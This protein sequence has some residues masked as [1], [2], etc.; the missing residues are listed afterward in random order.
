MQQVTEKPAGTHWLR[1]TLHPETNI[2]FVHCTYPDI[3]L[4]TVAD[5][6]M[7]LF[8][9]HWIQKLW[10]C[11]NPPQKKKTNPKTSGCCCRSDRLSDS[12]CCLFEEELA[13]KRKTEVQLLRKGSLK[14]GEVPPWKRIT[15]FISP[16]FLIWHTLCHSFLSLHLSSS[17]LFSLIFTHS[18]SFSF[19]VEN[20]M[21]SWAQSE[22]FFHCEQ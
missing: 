22:T 4:R 6:W 19:S 16:P 21:A 8:Q 20:L 7:D 11:E 18:D 5:T 3:L 1:Q 2:K 17:S 14:V 15:L 13:L 9:V 10:S 12:V